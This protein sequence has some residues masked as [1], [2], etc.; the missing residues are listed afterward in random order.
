M[1]KPRIE[2]LAGDFEGAQSLNVLRTLA[3]HQPLWDRFRRFSGYFLFKGLLPPRERELVI[4]R[5]GWRCESEYEFG[6][7]TTMGKEAGVTEK[8]IQRLAQE[9]TD[10]WSEA[11][12]AL[13]AFADE[14]C[15]TNTVSDPTWERLAGRW[16]EGEL[17]ELVMVAGC[18]R[19]VSGFLNAVKVQREPGVPGWPANY[20]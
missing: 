6:Q 13:V 8:E 16:S 1:A 14:L 20:G 12:R 19:M 17:M 3:H 7:H 2:P 15:A 18:Y 11:D 5:V 4:L 9:S 10:G